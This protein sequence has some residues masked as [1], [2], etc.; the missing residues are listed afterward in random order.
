MMIGSLS[1][2]AITSLHD[3]WYYGQTP[4][5]ARTGKNLA[6]ND[7]EQSGYPASNTPNLNGNDMYI[8]GVMGKIA[9][10]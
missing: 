6:C 5:F 10:L 4:S 8:W 9:I 7:D 1:F 2:P 3:D